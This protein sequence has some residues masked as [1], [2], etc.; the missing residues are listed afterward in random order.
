[1]TLAIGVMVSLF[2]AVTA[3]RTFLHLTLDNIQSAKHPKW[4]GV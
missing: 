1:L 2:T 4:F 3:T